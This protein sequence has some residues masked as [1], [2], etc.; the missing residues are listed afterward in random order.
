[1]PQIR[2][3]HHCRCRTRYMTS[4]RAILELLGLFIRGLV[5]EVVVL[6]GGGRVPL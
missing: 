2:R 5:G 6:F 1:M 4:E 3:C